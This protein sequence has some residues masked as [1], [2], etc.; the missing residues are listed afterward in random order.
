MFALNTTG[1]V[2]QIEVSAPRE[3]DVAGFAATAIVSLEEQPFAVA[4]TQY[5]PG[6]ITEYVAFV[7]PSCH[8]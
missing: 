5:E 1:V 2:E 8:R 6:F 3:N 4:C 7:D